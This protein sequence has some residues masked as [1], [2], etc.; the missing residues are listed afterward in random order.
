MNVMNRYAW[1]PLL[2]VLLIAACLFSYQLER[3]SLWIDELYSVRDALKVFNLDEFTLS[4]P[5]GIRMARPLYYLLLRL[6]MQINQS[7]AWMRGFS[8]ISAL[9]CVFLTYKLGYSLFKMKSV[10]IVAS[11]LLMFSPL[12]L[13]YAQELRMYA[14]GSFLSLLG[15]M[16]FLTVLKESSQS[17]NL[18][19]WFIIRLLMILTVPLTLLQI[20][21]DLMILWM[22]RKQKIFSFT[23]RDIINR[24][25]IIV[26]ISIPLIILN[27][28]EQKHWLTET[29]I[30]N[31]DVSF[32]DV[33]LQL[34]VSRPSQNLYV[35]CLSLTLIIIF[36]LG[37]VC[38]TKKTSQFE[39]Y[40]VAAWTFFPGV[41]LYLLAYYSDRLLAK[42]YWL[43]IAP[44]FC[45]LIVSGVM[46]IYHS[47]LLCAT[48]LRI[49]IC[50]VIAVFYCLIAVDGIQK[51]YATNTHEDWR[52]AVQI[53]KENKKAND[54]ILFD[55][56]DRTKTALYVY[57][58]ET[59]FPYTYRRIFNDTTT[60]ADI[61]TESQFSDCQNESLRIWV[62]LRAAE[63][64]TVAINEN[65]FSI[66]S[67]WTPRKLHLF[68]I[69][70]L[71]KQKPVSREVANHKSAER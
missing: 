6:W 26:I 32:A 62:I 18:N 50:T 15:S 34:I 52:L 38:V 41:C 21:A 49:G 25:A 42:Q 60:R 67:E 68:L 20:P 17:S 4:H 3:Q 9:G 53:I 61:C 55:S 45:L 28:F 19:W 31:V 35:I 71:A 24:I 54:I 43:F 47:M 48:S 16:V 51:F 58:K 23:Y 46:Y 5:L 59:L 66:L 7:V 40:I 29:H 13:A 36:V 22:L 69:T 30:L 27:Y 57:A 8:V 44:Y 70:S 65:E 37:Y 1:L 11:I 63:F 10:G 56:L 64:Q 33:L 14:L 2:G 12:F 39:C